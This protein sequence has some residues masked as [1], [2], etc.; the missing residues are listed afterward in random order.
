M[1]ECGG[2]TQRAQRLRRGR[3]K[4]TKNGFGFGVKALRFVVVLPHSRAVLANSK[5]DFPNSPPV[6]GYAV[7]GGGGGGGA[8]AVCASGQHHPARLRL[9]HLDRGIGGRWVF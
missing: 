7:G 4:N 1:P 2:R 9:P 5:P 3:R 6:E 8:N